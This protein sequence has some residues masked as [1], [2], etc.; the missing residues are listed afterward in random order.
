MRPTPP[1]CLALPHLHPPAQLQKW[2]TI[3]NFLF[4]SKGF[5]FDNVNAELPKLAKLKLYALCPGQAILFEVWKGGIRR[6]W[7]SQEE[8][9]EVGGQEEGRERRISKTY[10]LSD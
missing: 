2:R 6:K 5:Q 4:S 8:V 10:L 7:I 9:G 3:D 1:H